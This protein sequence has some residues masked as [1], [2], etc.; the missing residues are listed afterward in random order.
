MVSAAL[1]ASAAN[2][3]SHESDAVREDLEAEKTRLKEVREITKVL[4]V[5][6]LFT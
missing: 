6:D 2:Q 1:A 5:Y 4:L 3:S